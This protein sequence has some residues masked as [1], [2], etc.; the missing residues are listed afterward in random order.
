M[1]YFLEYKQ[2]LQPYTKETLE[3]AGVK[4]NDVKVDELT[5]FFDYFTFN[6]TNAVIYSHEELKNIPYS[7]LARQVRLNQKAFNVDIE[8][9]SDVATDAEIKIF[10]GPKYDSYGHPLELEENWMNFIQLD[11]FKQK[12]TTGKNSI[13]R[14]SEDFVFFKDDSVSTEKL[15]S[16]LN[17]GKIPVDQS[18]N[19]FL[20]P[21]RLMLPKGTKGG[22][23]F[24]IFVV[25]YPYSASAVSDKFAD[26]KP[27][28]YPLDRPVDELHFYQPNM[29][30]K[31]VYIHHEG[32]E[33]VLMYNS[34]K[35][36]F[37]YPKVFPK[38]H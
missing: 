10:L 23:P 20:L 33:S 13:V 21:R 37:P 6:T 25:V 8:I 31:D 12:L 2:Y 38:T 3:F 22:Y 11:M 4:I 35:Y 36:I 19:L 30:F 18:E 29:F 7:F 34:P 5:T 26:G 14:N 1:F 32:A 15:Y 9:K 24:Q 16:F 27:L 28:S 17:Q